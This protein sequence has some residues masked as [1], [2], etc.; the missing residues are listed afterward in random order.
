[1]A[2]DTETDTDTDLIDHDPPRWEARL[3]GTLLAAV[4]VGVQ[5]VTDELG[6]AA[7]P[8]AHRLLDMGADTLAAAGLAARIH[9]GEAIDEGELVVAG[10]DLHARQLRLERQLAETEK[11]GHE[12]AARFNRLVDELE[13]IVDPQRALLLDLE[14]VVDLL[15]QGYKKCADCGKAPKKGS[16]A[17][18]PDDFNEGLILD[19]E[20]AGQHAHVGEPAPARAASAPARPDELLG[21]TSAE[22]RAFHA[23]PPRPQARRLAARRRR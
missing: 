3:I 16:I 2:T 14:A 1:M 7:G 18:S 6:G 22:L 21:P 11:A 17:A 23:N 8:A 15:R 9:G 12:W 5:W 10:A 20:L 4:A 19:E 13:R